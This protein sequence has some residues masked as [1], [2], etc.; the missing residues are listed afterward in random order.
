MTYLKALS[1][2]PNN[3]IEQKKYL[4]TSFKQI[5]MKLKYFIKS[6]QLNI[7]KIFDV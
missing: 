5:M 7:H 1:L 6:D 2:H 3:V 4:R